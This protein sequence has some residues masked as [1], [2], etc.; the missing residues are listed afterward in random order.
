MSGKPMC[1]ARKVRFST[2]SVHAAGKVNGSY[3]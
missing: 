3:V 2:K 1:F